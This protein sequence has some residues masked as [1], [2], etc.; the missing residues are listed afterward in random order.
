MDVN[1]DLQLDLLGGAGDDGK[2]SIWYNDGPAGHDTI[3]F[4]V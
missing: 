2:R 4:T 3:S 1:A